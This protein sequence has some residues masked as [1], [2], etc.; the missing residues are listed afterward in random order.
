MYH[1]LFRLPK[2]KSNHQVRKTDK[3]DG[4]SVFLHEFFTV[5]IRHNLSV[6]ITDIEALCVEIINKKTK[7]ILISTKYCQQVGY[8]NEFQSY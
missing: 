8:S 4:I 7:Y 2:Y 5:N 6:N 1:N 3:G